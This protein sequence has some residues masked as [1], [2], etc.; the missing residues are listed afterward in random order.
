MQTQPPTQETPNNPHP[1]STPEINTLISESPQSSIPIDHQRLYNR[2]TELKSLREQLSFYVS[3]NTQ[4]KKALYTK[5]QE[6]IEYQR[7]KQAYTKDKE[8]LLLEIKNLSTQNE[9]LQHKVTTLEQNLLF[10]KSKSTQLESDIT[11]LTND[12]SKLSSDKSRLKSNLQLFVEENKE[13]AKHIQHLEKSISISEN[14]IQKL[15]L[16][17]K[18][19]LARLD[20]LTLYNNELAE[21][22][23]NMKLEQQQTNEQLIQAKN[24]I[25]IEKD[26]N[27]KNNNYLTKLNSQLALYENEINELKAQK[28]ELNVQN[29]ITMNNY[30]GYNEIIK[31]YE[32]VLNEERN[33]NI[34][35]IAVINA[36]RKE[37]GLLKEENENLINMQ[38]RQ[39]TQT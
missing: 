24:E 27:D 1:T 8:T 30:V 31:N 16:T 6:Q 20:N 33:K 5:K 3:E 9:A 21:Q 7:S 2:E 32:N 37:V 28:D 36:L 38:R 34:N 35:N 11:S 4:L 17:N 19:L 22:I 29:K 15:S 25:K 23:E 39:I 10:Y 18:E 13:A 12:Y 14:K 26:V